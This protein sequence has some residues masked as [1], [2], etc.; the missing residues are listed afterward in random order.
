[1]FRQ[2]SC[3]TPDTRD[4]QD[5][6]LHIYCYIVGDCKSLQKK[7]S[8]ELRGLA[9]MRAAWMA[10]MAVMK[11]T[12]DGRRTAVGARAQAQQ[13]SRTRLL[14]TR[15]PVHSLR[16][17]TGGKS[18]SKAPSFA[19]ALPQVVGNCPSAM[20]ARPPSCLVVD[21]HCELTFA[22]SVPTDI[23]VLSSSCPL[24]IRIHLVNILRA[25]SNLLERTI[26]RVQQQQQQ[27]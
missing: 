12:S 21:P 20:L 26:P 8:A 14:V 27:C 7:I 9:C 24:G 25:E 10:A 17:P 6:M 11:H 22:S 18:G 1:M 3:Y 2:Q 13:G 19:F 4:Y 23:V 15:R 5:K 16:S